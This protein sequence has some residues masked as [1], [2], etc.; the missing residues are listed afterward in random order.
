MKERSILFKADEV[1]ATLAERKRQFR[2]PLRLQPI[3]IGY[4]PLE[5]V[6]QPG[7]RP[8]DL[9]SFV[10]SYSPFGIPGGTLWVKE[11]WAIKYFD[12]HMAVTHGSFAPVYRASWIDCEPSP[13]WRSS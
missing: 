8:H 6:R 13:C 9:E 10:D 12:A 3:V 1:T 7:C 11:T 2:R 4:D 5:L